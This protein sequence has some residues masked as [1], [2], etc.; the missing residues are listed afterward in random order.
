M[1]EL[2]FANVGDGDAALIREIS[3]GE[4]RMTVLVDAGRPFVEPANV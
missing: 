2:F 3:D 1:L 4:T